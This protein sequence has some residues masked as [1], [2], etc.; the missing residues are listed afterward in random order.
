MTEVR[1]EDIERFM[2]EYIFLAVSALA[3]TLN[4]FDESP[5]AASLSEAET[6]ALTVRL[7]P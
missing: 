4:V 3:N 2:S 6:A 5:T 7:R 1:A